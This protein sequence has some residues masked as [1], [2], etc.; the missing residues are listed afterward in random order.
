[1]DCFVNQ[2]KWHIVEFAET[3]TAGAVPDF[4]LRNNG[5]S[6]IYPPW[7]DN[8]PKMVKAISLRYVPQVDWKFYQLSKVFWKAGTYFEKCLN[9]WGAIYYKLQIS[10]SFQNLT[11]R[12]LM[13][14]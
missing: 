2:G 12:C 11:L 10:W 5:T 14:S 9:E 8:D 6:V 7:S 13:M 1:M 3:K 4:W